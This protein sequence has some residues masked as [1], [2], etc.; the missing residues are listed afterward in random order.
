V[1]KITTEEM[2]LAI[3]T[4]IDETDQIRYVLIK[5]KIELQVTIPS[6]EKDYDKY[7]LLHKQEFKLHSDFKASGNTYNAKEHKKIMKG[8]GR[9][10]AQIKIELNRSRNEL[11]LVAKKITQADDYI[12]KLEN[13]AENLKQFK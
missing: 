8:L 11:E 9:K 4:K 1:V 10:H 2:L 7:G 13:K 12:K 6:L 5:R 3:C